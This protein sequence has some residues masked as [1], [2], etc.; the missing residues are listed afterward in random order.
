M[1]LVTEGQF[2]LLA[3]DTLMR[4]WGHAANQ[5]EMVIAIV[6]WKQDGTDRAN[7]LTYG[8]TVLNQLHGSKRVH[9]RR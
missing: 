6:V 9:I 2:V 7:N 1:D 3:W 8:T 5:S 4:I